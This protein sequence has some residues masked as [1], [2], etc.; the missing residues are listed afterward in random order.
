MDSFEEIKT[1]IVQHIPD[2]IVE[3]DDLTGTANH[4]GLIVVSDTFQDLPLLEQHRK[5]M[6][7][8]SEKLSKSLHAV[9]IK[10]YTKKRF[11]GLKQN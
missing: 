8:L 7:V 1:L 11:Q 5:V 3:I 2:A 9:K 6:S 10:T 4:L